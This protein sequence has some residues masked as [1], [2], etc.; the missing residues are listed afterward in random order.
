MAVP[1]PAKRELRAA[2]RAARGAFT[3]GG[4]ILLAP[5]FLARLSPGLTVATY[6]PMP[7]EVD[8]A[9]L[10]E[11]AHAA[12]CALALPRVAGRDMPMRFVRWT[13]GAA[14]EGG[15]FGIEQPPAG[16]PDVSPDIVLAPLLG[17]DRRGNR[18][19]QGAGYYDRAFAT[20]PHAWRVGVAWSVQEAAVPVEDWD[21]PLH[22]IATEKEWITP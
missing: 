3:P 5:A 7:D 21:V 22:A 17:F 6:R 11:A 4:P 2:L 18:L 9:P 10:A 20:L 8:P 19:G 12:G 13:P 15:P 1:S 14:L 16:A